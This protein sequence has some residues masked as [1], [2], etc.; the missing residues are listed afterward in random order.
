MSLTNFWLAAFRLPSSYLKEIER[1][2]AA[3]LWSGPY[4]KN[5]K[6]KVSWQDKYV[7][8]NEGGWGIKSLKEINKVTA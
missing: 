2:C 7:P 4:L 3:F 8:K 1:L 6:A 5:P